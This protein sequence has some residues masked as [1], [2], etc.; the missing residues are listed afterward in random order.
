[1]TLKTSLELSMI[2]NQA[3][4]KAPRKVNKADSCHAKLFP[5]LPHSLYEW[6][7]GPESKYCLGFVSLKISIPATQL[8]WRSVKAIDNMQTNKHGCVAIKLYLQT[9]KFEFHR[10]FMPSDILLSFS[11]V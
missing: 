1:M 4:W 7:A 5:G 9:L 11:F 2:F 3:L 6:Q 10:I 8:C